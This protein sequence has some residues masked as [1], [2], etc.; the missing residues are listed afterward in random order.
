MTSTLTDREV[1][2]RAIDI[3]K[4]GWCKHYI[5]IDCTGGLTNE[6]SVGAVAWCAL[7]AI[8][9]ALCNPD[10]S[11][12]FPDNRVMNIQHRFQC[13]YNTCL[14]DF[15]DGESSVEPVIA[16]LRDFASKLEISP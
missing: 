3:L 9:K 10:A 6:L 16:R 8:G 4:K 11:T 1:V 7:G 12:P 2:L 14:S 15:N 13:I 5:A